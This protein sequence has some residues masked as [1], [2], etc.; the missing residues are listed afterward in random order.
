MKLDHVAINV[1][2]ISSS[3]EWYRENHKA[4]ILYQDDT[5]AMLLI[6]G[7]KLA[8][9]VAT[10]HPP[11]IAFEVDSVDKFPPG[12][13]KYHRD[14]SAYLYTKDPEGNVIEYI[15]WNVQ[16]IS[17]KKNDEWVGSWED[18]SYT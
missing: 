15:C 17:Q 14:G 4:E 3:V 13:F 5:W 12:E 10:E 1:K 18:I 16:S 6:G 7:V 8:L 9:T 2:E 11:H